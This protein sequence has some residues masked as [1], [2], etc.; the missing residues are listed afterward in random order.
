MIVGL[1]GTGIGG[2]FYLLSALWMPVREAWRALSG[3]AGPRRWRTVATLAGLAAAIYL[4]LWASA[5]ALDFAL[6]AA[7]DGP[8]ATGQPEPASSALGVTATYVTAGALLAVLLLVEIAAVAVGR[9]RAPSPAER[10]SDVPVDGETDARRA[11]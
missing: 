10:Q 7:H 6:P 2:L 4:G 9:R 5:W 8:S 11:A 1:P 3:R